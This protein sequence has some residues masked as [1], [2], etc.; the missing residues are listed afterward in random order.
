LLARQFVRHGADVVGIDISPDQIA[1]AT[2]LSQE[3]GL[4]ARFAVAPA[5]TTG[6]SAAASAH[7]AGSAPR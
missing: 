2:R 7:A 3:E 5:E 4:A 6:Q 1:M